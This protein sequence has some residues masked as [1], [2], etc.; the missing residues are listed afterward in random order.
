[1]TE[2]QKQDAEPCACDNCGVDLFTDDRGPRQYR[3]QCCECSDFSLCIDCYLAGVEVQT[4]KASHAMYPRLVL[5]NVFADDWSVDEELFLLEALEL[6]GLGNWEL[7]RHH[8]NINHRKRSVKECFLHYWRHYGPGGPFY[9][10]LM[11]TVPHPDPRDHQ[12][13]LGPLYDR[14]LNEAEFGVPIP[15]EPDPAARPDEKP[16]PVEPPKVEPPPTS[17]KAKTKAKPKTVAGPAVAR[18][19]EARTPT[20]NYVEGYWPLRGDFTVEYDDNAEDSIA[21]LNW[22]AE[23]DSYDAVN[24]KI[25]ILNLFVQRLR[26]RREKKEI[27]S[28]GLLTQKDHLAKLQR[29]LQAGTREMLVPMTAIT[30]FFRYSLD[31]PLYGKLL[32]GLGKEAEIRYE[33]ARLQDWRINGITKFA[34]GTTFTNEQRKVQ[35]KTTGRGRGRGRGGRRGGRTPTRQ[36]AP[37]VDVNG[38]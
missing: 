36:P 24:M 31:D 2:E 5:P 32:L 22:E 8:V 21:D 38:M 27:V 26:A 29:M 30:P 9:S 14:E 28:R 25:I 19:G 23:T 17:P 4:H 18:T 3:M 7:T 10:E 6:H 35:T 11:K 16:A 20:V 1:M 15:I 12:K 34:D 37:V 13:E 33:I